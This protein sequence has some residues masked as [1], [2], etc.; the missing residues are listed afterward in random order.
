MQGLPQDLEAALQRLQR[1]G[2]V[3]EEE[4]TEAELQA[5]R[6]LRSRYLAYYDGYQ[7]AYYETLL[8]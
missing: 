4:L 8:E 1:E 2:K 3:L 6:Q 7:R 5:Y